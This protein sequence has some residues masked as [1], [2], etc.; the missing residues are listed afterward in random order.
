MNL[1]S[2]IVIIGTGNVA[3][4]FSMA[5]CKVGFNMLQVVGRN[6]EKADRLAKLINAEAI[7]DLQNINKSADLY[8]IA[9]SDDAVESISGQIPQVDG[10]VV[11]TSGA[12]SI[13]VLKARHAHGGVLYPI[14]SF[15]GQ[16]IDFERVPLCVEGTDK[17]IEWQL[18]ELSKKIRALPTILA[19]EERLKIHLAAVIANNFTNYLWLKTEAYLGQNHLDFK[20]LQPLIQQSAEK[21]RTTNAADSQ[22]G[23]AKRGDRSTIEKHLDLLHENEELLSIYRNFTHSIY[24]YFHEKNK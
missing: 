14:F 9:V 6:P 15:W 2:N 13:E 8:L 5:F 19:S 11:H 21:L 10:I 4:A 20:L 17:S 23:P 24:D 18:Q 16:E 22:T 3:K 12:I 1:I 7:T